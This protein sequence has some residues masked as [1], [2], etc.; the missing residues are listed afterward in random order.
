MRLRWLR[1]L[2]LGLR[3]GPRGLTEDEL[4][5]H[6]RELKQLREER[7]RLIREDFGARDAEIRDAKRTLV[8]SRAEVEKIKAAGAQKLADLTHQH[9]VE[10]QEDAKQI[11]EYVKRI[12]DDGKRIAA[13]EREVAALKAALAD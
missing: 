8:D 9:A 4:A 11:A 5:E 12:A 7:S 2:W 6:E 10:R 3:P 1:L 13:L